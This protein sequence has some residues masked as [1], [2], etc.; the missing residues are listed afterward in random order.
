[1]S[2]NARGNYPRWAAEKRRCRTAGWL[3]RCIASLNW[4]GADVCLFWSQSPL[5][6]GGAS[7]APPRCPEQKEFCNSGSKL[8]RRE[9][10]NQGKKPQLVALELERR[11]ARKW[12]EEA[13]DREADYWQRRKE[14]A[15][16]WLALV[17]RG[18]RQRREK[19]NASRLWAA[20]Q[21]APGLWPT[22]GLGGFAWAFSALRMH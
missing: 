1:M 18:E 13:G 11:R 6:A 16:G 10:D 4:G 21:W 9:K 5:A 14:G 3:S 8:T 19:R 7:L 2:D 15:K 12:G 17:E 22:A 20:A